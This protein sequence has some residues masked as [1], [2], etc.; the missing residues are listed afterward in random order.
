MKKNFLFA[1]AMA[2]V[3]AGCSSD[4]VTDSGVSRADE[5]YMTVSLVL[6]STGVTRT[7][8]NDQF[9]EGEANE[10]E[11][12]DITL[13][14]FDVSNNFL[15][16]ANPGVPSPW[17][18]VGSTTNVTTKASLTAKIP[19]SKASGGNDAVKVFAVLNNNSLF[20]TTV[21]TGTSFENFN[22]VVSKSSEDLKA[23]GFTMSNAVLKIDANVVQLVD[24][25][26]Y[27][28]KTEAE[29]K[30][31]PAVE[32]HVERALAKVSL[33][34]ESNLTSG[35]GASSVYN[36]S[37]VTIEGWDLDNVNTKLYPA[38]NI[39]GCEAESHFTNGVVNRL[40]GT[41]APIRHYWGIDPN[42][43]ATTTDLTQKDAATFV[44]T[45]DNK[46]CLENTFNVSNQKKTET[47]RV[48]LKAKFT[49]SLA[50]GDDYIA[51][52]DYTWYTLGSSL[53]YYH[54][55]FLVNEIINKTALALG[56]ATSAV[57]VEKAII[58]AWNAGIV[59]DLTAAVKVNGTNLTSTENTK[60][61][62]KLGKV[63]VFKDAM[64]YYPIYIKHFGDHYTP[65][66]TAEDETS[67]G[68]TDNEARDQ[69]YLGRYG[70]L[71]NNWYEL[72]VT[73]VYH[74][75]T[76]TIPSIPD[77]WDDIEENWIACTINILS[78]A[79]RTQDVEL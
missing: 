39:T 5:S 15:G 27:I 78:W 50:S 40:Y 73:K 58:A 30:A 55:T 76:P 33:K 53:N 68:N 54:G 44:F 22:A 37:T 77:E 31:N 23:N 18:H 64:C 51:S 6:P 46:Y 32:I 75:G 62:E 19:V 29:A 24:C 8:A 3:F 26:S 71:R 48:V 4:D 47:T 72:N 61:I 9:A 36:G 7:E 59:E 43:N 56:V 42:Y 57:T 17:T 21:T 35:I 13:Y 14:F 52:G 20:P 1:M 28:Y 49:P 79:K 70:V 67:Y 25:N 16:S 10:Y 34:S 38:R 60:V 63:T 41:N 2:A 66:T 74:P 11:V 69:K 65:W 12:K 45:T